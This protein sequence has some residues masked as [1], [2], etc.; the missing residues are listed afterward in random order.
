[1]ERDGLNPDVMD[2]DHNLPVVNAEKKQEKKQKETHRRA[3][4][5]WKTIGNVVR[6][7]LWAKVEKEI[8]DIDIDE[9]E[10]EELF[11]AD[12]QAP[13]K[14]D[15]AA[16]ATKKKGAAVRVIDAKRANNGGIILAR[17]KMTHDEMADAVD[18]IDSDVLSA[19]QIEN[20]IEYLPTKD[21][22]D[23]LE[24]YMLEGGQDAASKFDGLCECEK[25]MVSMMTVKHA[26][27]KIRAL[28]FKLQF[29][30]CMESIAED[31]Q[32]IDNACDELLHSNRLRQLL[33]IILHF[34]NKL[35]TSGVNSKGK[36]GAFSLDSLSKLS[37]A[38][39]FDKKTTFLH[40]I[41]LIVQRNNE[42]LLK[43][44]DDIP[45]V[46][47]ADKVFWDQCLQDLEEVENQLENVR[48][49][50][51]YEAKVSK[52]YQLPQ[53]KKHDDD[54]TLD[55]VEELTLEEEVISLRATQ[56]GLF[57]LGAIKQVS[58]LRDKI[59]R[60][61]EKFARVLEYFGEGRK[62]MQPQELFSIIS[63][64]TRDFQ[65]SKEEVFTTVS[66]RLREDRKK[67]RNQATPNQKKGLPPAAPERSPQKPMMKASSHQP[68]MS[69]LFSDI[70]KRGSATADTNT[71]GPSSSQNG[72]NSMA[73]NHNAL[74][75]SLNR[76]NPSGSNPAKTTPTSPQ[77]RNFHHP[78][79][80]PE[81]TT[82]MSPE[83][84]N[85]PSPSNNTTGPVSI[86]LAPTTT[87]HR[88]NPASSGP[89]LP[90]RVRSPREALR[91][92]QQMEA[93]KA[94]T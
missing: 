60:T 26:K 92:R 82:A 93:R 10:F 49:I 17:L 27:R 37:Q 6:N 16:N 44:Y 63:S 23:S 35:N 48:R 70:K 73:A 43:Y 72:T 33:G 42:L 86:A 5:H 62:N 69:S 38:K 2:Q 83:G 59:D 54:E 85:G 30:S 12:L 91:I 24:K 15:S 29:L 89:T 46:L 68:N 75:N 19:E 51:L 61:R 65:N 78:S 88:S 25:F 77:F 87:T 45:T 47:K 52:Q 58:A 57:T 7:S 18:R 22:R 67:A 4:L 80:I 71:S 55:D 84:D 21:E 34:G 66:K 94:Q 76:A 8:D 81:E 41:V 11:K 74:M 90:R 14:T 13:K 50:S 31:A 32:M 9:D 79:R 39:A 36:A 56:I 53:Q 40:Y 64:F 28:L 20:I 3:R 1:M